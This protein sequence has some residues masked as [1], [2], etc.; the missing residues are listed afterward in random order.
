MK[1]AKFERESDLCA[2]FIAWAA[3]HHPDVGVFA[4]WD[5]WDILLVYPE[6]WQLGIQA[7]LRLNA[8]VMLQAA[9]NRW[10]DGEHGP[11]FRA[12]LVPEANGYAE[13]ARRLG[14]IVF[15]PRYRDVFRDAPVRDFLPGLRDGWRPSELEKPPAAD[16][17][18]WNPVR[19]H[20]LPPVATTDAIAGSPCPVSLTPWKLGALAV[21]AELELK[22]TISTKRIQQL[23]IDPR[24]WTQCS[25]L[26]PAEKRGQWVRGEKCP[27]FDRQHPTAFAAA[28]T[29]AQ[30]VLPLE[31]T[32]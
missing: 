25:W 12:L 30:Q 1:A 21:L 23:G 20:K 17:C 27:P 6:G 10:H 24:R 18:D 9:P 32:P 2:A 15:A 16:W 4:E 8:T 19:R 29:K 26:L 11:D 7:K 31:A 22:G 13:V 14:L 28:L 5:G 3:K